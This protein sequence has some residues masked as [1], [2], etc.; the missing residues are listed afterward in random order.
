MHAA[1]AQLASAAVHLY[2]IYKR[3]SASRTHAKRQKQFALCSKN[4]IPIY[5]TRQ[6]TL[7]ASAERNNNLQLARSF[8]LL[9]CE[10]CIKSTLSAFPS[11]FALNMFPNSDAGKQDLHRKM[12]FRLGIEIILYL[13]FIYE[14]LARGR[15]NERDE[16]RAK[17]NQKVKACEDH[18]KFHAS[19]FFL[20]KLKIS[21]VQFAVSIESQCQHS[22]AAA[23][24]SHCSRCNR[25]DQQPALRSSLLHPLMLSLLTQIK[26]YL[27]L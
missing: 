19:T 21:Q 4:Y 8:E 20:M 26:Y 16:V 18:R 1:A 9:L 14:W 10:K 24:S 13:M 27:F 17:T 22:V 2:S 23:A 3:A 12:H 5:V 7:L 15:S 25:S 6:T 11:K